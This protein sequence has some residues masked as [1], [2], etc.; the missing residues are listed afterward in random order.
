M[1]LTHRQRST[2][3]SLA[4]HYFGLGSVVYLFGSRI[5]DQQKGGDIDLLIETQQNLQAFVQAEIYFRAALDTQI[6]EQKID[7]L[8]YNPSQASKSSKIIEIALIT[9][10]RL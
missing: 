6:G 8:I 9:A 7:I 1:R 3:K 4:N 5:D 2:I 10:V